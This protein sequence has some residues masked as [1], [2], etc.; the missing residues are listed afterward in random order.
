MACAV[1]VV[2]TNGGA[3]PEIVGDAGVV[4]PSADATA[5][6][7]AIAGLLDDPQTRSRLGEAARERITQRFSWT[8]CAEE[9]VTYYRRVIAHADH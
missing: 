2:S 3:L 7:A 1:P 9:M 8:R 5:L 4:V 6:R